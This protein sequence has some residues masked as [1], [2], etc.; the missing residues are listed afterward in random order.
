MRGEREK[1][2]ANTFMSIVQLDKANSSATVAMLGRAI[3]TSS[4]EVHSF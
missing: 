1:K 4:T 2:S 3:V